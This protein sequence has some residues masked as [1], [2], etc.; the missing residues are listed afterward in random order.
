MY[1]S[2]FREESKK[3]GETNPRVQYKRVNDRKRKIQMNAEIFITER[4]RCT[5]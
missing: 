4:E 2:L 1:E 5:K 3:K